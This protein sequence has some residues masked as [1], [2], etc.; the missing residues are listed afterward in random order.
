MDG[1]ERILCTEN[2]QC[3]GSSY[4][5]WGT[6]AFQ[7]AGMTGEALSG[8]P[9]WG[10]ED[11]AVL[12]GTVSWDRLDLCWHARVDLSINGDRDRWLTFSPLSSKNNI[13][14]IS[15]GKCKP[16]SATLRY[17]R[18]F[19]RNSL[20]FYWPRQQKHSFPLT[21]GIWKFYAVLFDH[22]LFLCCLEFVWSQQQAHQ[23]LYLG[24]YSPTLDKLCLQK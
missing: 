16:H 12:K 22:L 19:G 9:L 7:F 24:D 15:C 8:P 11:S 14:F 18:V 20:V 10:R 6:V 4:N 5:K 17:R 21:G 2:D 23:L 1:S 13:F 3:P